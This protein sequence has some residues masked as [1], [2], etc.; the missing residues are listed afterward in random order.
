MLRELVRNLGTVSFSPN[1][2]AVVVGAIVLIVVSVASK[3]NAPL[4]MTSMILM[5]FASAIGY[6][7]MRMP[8]DASVKLTI[9]GAIVLLNEFFE[10]LVAF[11]E[12]SNW[13]QGLIRTMLFVIVATAL[14]T[15]RKKGL[16]AYCSSLNDDVVKR[17]Q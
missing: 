17:M 11:F 5:V 3:R 6:F 8:V 9:V 2:L 10:I 4:E 13:I 1:T 12:R 7:M 14:V 16:L 15:V